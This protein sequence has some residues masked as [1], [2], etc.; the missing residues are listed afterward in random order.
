MAAARISDSD[1]LGRAQQPPFLD[2]RQG[3]LRLFAQQRIQNEQLVEKGGSFEVSIGFEGGKGRV[4]AVEQPASFDGERPIGRDAG[5]S[6]DRR[7]DGVVRQ[8]PA[9][10]MTGPSAA[11][12]TAENAVW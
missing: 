12:S 6:E 5:M 8:G 2:H 11:C 10:L 4:P 1:D 7:E 9:L 3:A